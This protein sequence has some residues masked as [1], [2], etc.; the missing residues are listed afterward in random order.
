MRNA[1]EIAADIRKSDVWDYE[2]CT[3]LCTELCKAADMEEEWEAAST[4]DY[5]WN[6]PNR[7]PSFEEVVEAAAEKLGVEIY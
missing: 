7:G 2:L 5:D 1:I 3:E 4:G 6:D